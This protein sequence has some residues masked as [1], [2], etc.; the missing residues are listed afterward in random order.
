VLQVVV[1]DARVLARGHDELGGRFRLTRVVVM[2][3]S[4]LVEIGGLLGIGIRSIDDA[5]VGNAVELH[6]EG[7]V[8]RRV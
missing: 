5:V 4:D 2:D 1:G 3:L 8:E 6:L 7:V